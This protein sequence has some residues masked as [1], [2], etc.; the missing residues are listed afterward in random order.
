MKDSLGK[1]NLVR[2]VCWQLFFDVAYVVFLQLLNI[3]H[4]CVVATFPLVVFVLQFLVGTISRAANRAKYEALVLYIF[5][6][7]HVSGDL[8][9]SIR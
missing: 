1:T 2:H 6:I 9:L 4:F 7:I 5:E 3:S 8:A